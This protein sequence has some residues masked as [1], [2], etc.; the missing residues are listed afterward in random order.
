MSD[1]AKAPVKGPSSVVP[2]GGPGATAVEFA[3]VPMYPEAYFDVVAEVSRFFA[4]SLG[5]L[6]TGLNLT[7]D[8]LASLNPADPRAGALVQRSLRMMEGLCAFKETWSGLGGS[9]LRRFERRDPIALARCVLDQARLG[10]EF[11][12]EVTGDAATS[13]LSCHPGLLESALQYLVRNAVD[14][15]PGGGHLGIDVRSDS[16]CTKIAVW[17]TGPG[18][19]VE[20]QSKILYEPVT[21]KPYGGGIGLM[22]VAMIA[23]R[24]HLGEVRWTSR[25]PQGC[26]IELTLPMRDA[27]VARTVP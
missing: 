25:M 4:H 26:I 9:D 7:L 24:V 8:M 6:L 14:A 16:A 5:N 12:A 13:A 23:K 17:D 1:D 22:L 3:R 27:N 18:I 10:A 2:P 11:S 19:P 15:M 20:L 21:T